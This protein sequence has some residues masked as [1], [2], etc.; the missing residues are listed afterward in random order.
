MHRQQ[1]WLLPNDMIY[2]TR[3]NGKQFCLNA[4]MIEL[5]ESTPD[6]IITLANKDKFIVK[7]AMDVVLEKIIQYKT[8]VYHSTMDISDSQGLGA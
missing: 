6:T 3:L 5:I 2:V 4:E 1:R 8:R 7:E